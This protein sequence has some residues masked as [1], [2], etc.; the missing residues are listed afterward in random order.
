MRGWW[1]ALPFAPSWTAVE[2]I[3]L[4]ETVA[5]IRSGTW[6]RVLFSALCAVIA[7]PFVAASYLIPF[8]L[9]VVAW[10]LKVRPACE[11]KFARGRDEEAAFNALA[12]INFVGSCAY[13][14][15]PVVIWATGETVGMLLAVAWVSATAAHDF[16]YF[17]ARRVL[18]A[19]WLAPLTL[20]IIAAPFMGAAGI[21]P[22]SM[23]G[24]ALLFALIVLGG[25]SGWDRRELLRALSASAAA[26][27]AAE[28]ASA[29]KTRFLALMSHELR[30]PLSAIIGYSEIIAE[31]GDSHAPDA[32]R[33]LAA[34]HR[35]LHIVNGMLDVSKLEAGLATLQ[36]TRAPVTALLDDLR[37]L[38]GPLAALRNNSFEVRA[39]GDLGVAS[40]DWARLCQSLAHLI[41]NAAKFTQEGAIEVIATRGKRGNRDVLEF[42]VRDTGIG[43]APE[44]QQEIFEPMVQ[45]DG[46]GGRRYGGAGMGLASARLVARLMGGDVICRSASGKGAVF[47]LWVEAAQEPRP[48]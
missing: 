10:E 6:P 15:F 31:S 8:M 14:T 13:C 5:L 44:R 27:E 36:P 30:T 40:V 22:L 25:I 33:V 24:G 45:A 3:G 34:A 16:V 47:T 18:V 12:A 7:S 32:R 9:F 23:A 42:A 17:A 29:A 19:S 35:L 37:R 2:R 41:D 21:S 26:R 46:S 43:V 20:A 11:D 38:G 4:P 1:S 48:T 28:Q 39:E